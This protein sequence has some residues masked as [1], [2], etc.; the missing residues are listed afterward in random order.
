MWRNLDEQV[1]RRTTFKEVP[2]S[3]QVRQLESAPSD[4]IC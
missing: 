3:L 2:T 4:Q 1:V